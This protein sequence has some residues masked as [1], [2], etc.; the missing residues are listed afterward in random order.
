MADLIRQMAEKPGGYMVTAQVAAVSSADGLDVTYRG[1]LATGLQFLSSYAAPGIGDVVQV[2]VQPGQMFVLGTIGTT[3]DALGPNLLPNPGF[4]LGG[5]YPSSWGALVAE[6]TRVSDPAVS[7]SSEA[8]VKYDLTGLTSG[9]G[10]SLFLAN[11]LTVDTGVTYRVAA[12]FL[13]AL[14][15]P[16]VAGYVQVKSA[17][18]QQGTEP[19]DP[20]GT[21]NTVAFSSV[22]TSWQE[23]AGTFTVPAG[24]EFASVTLTAQQTGAGR[25]TSTVYVDDVSMRRQL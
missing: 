5:T 22:T 12:W 4:E 14:T 2:W 24:H 11:P 17:P 6:V 19:F 1:G 3:G 20:G 25:V 8:S 16:N 9:T 18:T 15:D 23:V 13:S 21:V 7:H 10:R